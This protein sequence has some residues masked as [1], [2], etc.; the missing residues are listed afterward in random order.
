MN[1]DHSK[2]S[3]WLR[4]VHEDRKTFKRHVTH[5]G[6][7][8]AFCLSMVFM[9]CPWR[10]Y[11]RAPLVKGWRGSKYPVKIMLECHQHYFLLFLGLYHASS[12]R[13]PE[14]STVMWQRGMP[15][16]FKF[17]QPIS[18]WLTLIRILFPPLISCQIW[19]R[20]ARHVATSKC[21]EL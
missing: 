2:V 3:R 1:K 17:C 9:A 20:P 18:Y 19:K 12:S 4:A 13:R 5:I 10:C 11:W 21:F 16:P 15:A 14:L 8:L 7:S 6:T